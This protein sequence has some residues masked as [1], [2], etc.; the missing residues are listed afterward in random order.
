MRQ[1]VEYVLCT[2]G[3][4]SIVYET[5]APYRGPTGAP[6]VRPQPFSGRHGLAELERFL[7]GLGGLWGV[8]LV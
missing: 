3:G 4:P 1:K 6:S 7:G 2:I 5:Q 8:G